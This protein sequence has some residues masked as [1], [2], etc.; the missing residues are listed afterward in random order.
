MILLVKPFGRHAIDSA[1]INKIT[2]FK[3]AMIQS[4]IIYHMRIQIE[5]CSYNVLSLTRGF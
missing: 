4:R 5:E 1:H 2:I 3:H